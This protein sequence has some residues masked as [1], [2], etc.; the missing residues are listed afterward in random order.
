M[1]FRVLV[2]L[3]ESNLNTD[4]DCEKQPEEE[5]FCA[6]PHVDLDIAKA[7]AHKNFNKDTLKNDIALVKI[8][9]KIKF[10][11]KYFCFL[12][13]RGIDLIV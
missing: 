7:L 13:V 4:V 1:A 3:G 5:E 2:R 8:K 12:I 10:T 9:G 11:G 6:D